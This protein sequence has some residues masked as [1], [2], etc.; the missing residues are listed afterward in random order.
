MLEYV[1]LLHPNTKFT[2]YCRFD[3]FIC[4]RNILRIQI[5]TCKVPPNVR[6]YYSSSSTSG[7]GIKNPV[8]FICSKFNN[9]V[10][11]IFR[12]NCKMLISIMCLCRYLPDVSWIF[13]SGIADSKYWI[14]FVI[15][16]PFSCGMT[17]KF[18][19]ACRT[20]FFRIVT[21]CFGYFTR[22]W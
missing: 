17:F 3:I 9:S 15:S 13:S 19:I 7:K 5:Y 20:I 6:T 22:C 2:F 8:A 1:V 10:N 4:I 18:A 16:Y 21:I 14:M 12:K 11:Q